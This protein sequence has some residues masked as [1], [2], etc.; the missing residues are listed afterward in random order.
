MSNRCLEDKRKSSELLHN[1]VFKIIV[2]V[3][4]NWEEL[5]YLEPLELETTYMIAQ[6]LELYCF[7]VYGVV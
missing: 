1:F 3:V 5:C 4:P 6:T 7:I 2:H